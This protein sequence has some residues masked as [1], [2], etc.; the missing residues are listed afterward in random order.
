MCEVGFPA[1]TMRRVRTCL[2]PMWLVEGIGVIPVGARGWAAD[3]GGDTRKIHFGG[4]VVIVPE[5]Q[6]PR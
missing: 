1:C 6:R 2:A 4:G 5:G 3:R